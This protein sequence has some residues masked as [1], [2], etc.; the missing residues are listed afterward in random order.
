M[1]GAGDIFTLQKE[2]IDEFWPVILPFL[3]TFEAPDWTPHQVY[4]Q[5]VDGR[6]QLWGI[7][8]PTGIKGIWITRIHNT[9]TATYGLVWIAAG[10]GLDAGVPKFLECTETWFR[11]KD[12]EYIEIQGRKGWERVLPGY[13]PHAIVFRKRL[14]YGR[15]FQS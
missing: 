13:K 6:A 1:S 5:L 8:E 12:C 4:D 14:T 11:E 7:A 3:L 2:R 15:Q 9:A 10:T